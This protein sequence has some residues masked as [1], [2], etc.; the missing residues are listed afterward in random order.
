MIGPTINLQPTIL[1]DELVSIVPLKK[2]DF[3]KLYEIGSDPL[4]W[5]QHPTR[6]RYKEEV[7]QIYFDSAVQ[8]GSAFFL[9]NKATDELMGS[10][11]F[12]DYNPEQSRIAIG[13][14]FLARKFWGGEYNNR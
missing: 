13:F 6:D 3:E 9:Y 5:E 14:T 4:I 2:E 12:Y 1:E 10:S 11:R 7:F 8:S